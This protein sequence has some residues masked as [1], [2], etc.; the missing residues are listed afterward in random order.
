MFIVRRAQL[1]SKLANLRDITHQTAF[2]L[3]V[4]AASICASFRCYQSINNV[5]WW[6]SKSYYHWL[7]LFSHLK[8]LLANSTNFRSIWNIQLLPKVSKSISRHQ[9]SWN[10]LW[11]HCGRGKYHVSNSWSQDRR[12]NL[13]YISLICITNKYLNIHSL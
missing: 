10:I 4:G 6:N 2:S 8:H 13:N 11:R 1:A 3:A 5:M 7:S 9:N 12:T